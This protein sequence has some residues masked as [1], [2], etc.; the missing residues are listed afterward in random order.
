[1]STLFKVLAAFE[2]VLMAMV[3]LSWLVTGILTPWGV[4]VFVMS[5]FV[6]GAF[7]ATW[8]ERGR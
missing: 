5:S 6:I 2:A 3:A 1:M 8:L 4:L 7:F